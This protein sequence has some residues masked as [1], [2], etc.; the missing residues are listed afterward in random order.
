MGLRQGGSVRPIDDFS[1]YSHNATSET[2]ESPLA[3]GVDEIAAVSKVY[4]EAI[5]R[6]RVDVEYEDGSVDNGELH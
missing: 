2:L 4:L 5:A 1:I 3:G 6:G